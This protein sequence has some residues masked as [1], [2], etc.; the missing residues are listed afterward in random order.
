MLEN[1]NDDI[2]QIQLKIDKPATEVDSLGSVMSALEEIRK[3][4]AD[5]SH[6]VRPIN[7]MYALLVDPI[8]GSEILPQ[9]ELDS[10]DLI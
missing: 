6:D 10:Q 9:E 4:Q 2:K 7:A 1:L 3:K 5:F 8:L